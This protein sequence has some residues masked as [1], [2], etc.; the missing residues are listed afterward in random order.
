[1]FTTFLRSARNFREFASAEKIIQE[2]DLTL[3]Q[4]RAAC[5]EFN[6]NRS[7]RQIEAGTKMEFT[8]SADYLSDA[9]L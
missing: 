8:E 9:V 3:E 7:E 2:T 1:M 5:D 4:A 6:D